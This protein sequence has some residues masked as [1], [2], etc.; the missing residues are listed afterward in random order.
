VVVIQAQ[1][2]DYIARDLACVPAS[3]TVRVQPAA[4][5]EWSDL[6][7]PERVLKVVGGLAT[8]PRWLRAGAR[9]PAP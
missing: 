3:P 5:I 7:T 1:H 4:P 9:H 6:G 8:R 2:A